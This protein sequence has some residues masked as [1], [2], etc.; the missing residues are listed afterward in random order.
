MARILEDH[1]GT[2][3]VEENHPVGSRFL[4][5]LPVAGGGERTAA[6]QPIEVEDIAS[7]LSRNGGG[8]GAA[9]GSEVSSTDEMGG[10]DRGR[11]KGGR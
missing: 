10:K 6:E 4:V 1:G 8:E 7:H 3:R 11:K 9:P 5:E 2:V